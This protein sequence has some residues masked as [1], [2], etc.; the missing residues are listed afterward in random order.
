[1]SNRDPFDEMLSGLNRPAQPRPE[2]ARALE[3]RLMAELGT[4]EPSGKGQTDMSQAAATTRTWRVSAEPESGRRRWLPV[5]EIAAVV[6]IAIG[7]GGVV[8]GSRGM[9][10]GQSNDNKAAQSTQYPITPDPS[11]CTV[12][13]RTVEEVEKLV[14]PTPDYSELNLR[15][16]SEGTPPFDLQHSAAD[17]ETTR[18]IEAAY[19][20]WAA[21]INA[22]DSLRLAALTSDETI[23]SGAV[24]L[25]DP[26]D[27][28]KPLP[29]DQRLTI[30][31]VSYVREFD[32]GR[33]GGVLITAP[34]GF[35][36]AITPFFFIFEKQGDRW[37]LDGQP[38]WWA[39]EVG[40]SNEVTYEEGWGTP[41][42]MGT[43]PAVTPTVVQRPTDTQ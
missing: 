17:E 16:T 38:M 12:E 5:L 41:I 22:G 4:A 30:L 32:D 18:E 39:S 13:P 1:M 7:I 23:R 14:P 34:V 2:F 24:D 43:E 28:P 20:E 10:P 31:D 3:H 6:L 9:L 27:A 26:E 33:A 15:P 40:D 19:R 29:E 35:P 21:C 8:L 25:V 42:A 36:A 37:L 11:E